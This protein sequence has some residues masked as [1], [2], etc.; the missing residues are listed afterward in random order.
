VRAAIKNAGLIPNDRI[1]VN[2]APQMRKGPRSTS[3]LLSASLRPRA[4]L[5]RQPST[6]AHHGRTRSTAP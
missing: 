2:L 6:E 4:T 5:N 1:T 3:P